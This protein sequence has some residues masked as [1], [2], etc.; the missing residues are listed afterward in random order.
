MADAR[1]HIDSHTPLIV[2]V[3]GA[4]GLRFIAFSET[5]LRFLALEMTVLRLLSF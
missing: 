3:V 4:D 2:G 5:V 1:L